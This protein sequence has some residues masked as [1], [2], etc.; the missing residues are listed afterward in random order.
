MRHSKDEALNLNHHILVI[1]S[2]SNGNVGQLAV[3]CLVH[4]FSVA[5]HLDIRSVGT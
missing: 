2:V 4:N 1:P 5:K 3:E